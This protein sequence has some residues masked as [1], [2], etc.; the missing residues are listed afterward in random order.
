MNH[1]DSLNIRKGLE[2]EVP[3]SDIFAIRTSAAGDIL[4]KEVC[5]L[6]WE[7]YSKINPVLSEKISESGG[8]IYSSEKKPFKISESLIAYVYKSYI[9]DVETDLETNTIDAITNV[10]T[11][12]EFL[13][14]E[15]LNFDQFCFNI[16]QAQSFSGKYE[17]PIFKFSFYGY[18]NFS[19]NDYADVHKMVSLSNIHTL[20]FFIT[21]KN[22]V[23]GISAF[24]NGLHRNDIVRQREYLTSKE[25]A[26]LLNEAEMQFE[27]I[28]SFISKNINN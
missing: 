13:N 21:Y 20:N 28:S 25:F 8:T 27:M 16:M 14:T 11:E 7:A 17:N 19:L 22:V 23:S 1:L 6:G 2:L 4:A 5:D 12:I 3:V 15:I 10:S 24:L 9:V 18:G 26:S